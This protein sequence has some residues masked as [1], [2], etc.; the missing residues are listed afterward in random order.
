MKINGVD[1]V[2]Y[3]QLADEL[4]RGA[5]FVVFHYTISVFVVTFRR[6]SDIY[7]IRSG[8]SAV[9]KGLG[10]S[11]ISLFAGWWGIPWGP[12]FTIASFWTNFSGG[13]NVTAGVVQSLRPP[14][15]SA[16]SMPQVVPV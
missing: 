10:F 13:E 12:I 5:K 2:T 1:N 15:P 14:Q 4:Q 7:F 9:S 3:D 8:E 16:P 11:A 6:R